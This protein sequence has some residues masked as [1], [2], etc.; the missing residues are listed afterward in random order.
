M[1]QMYIFKNTEKMWSQ[2]PAAIPA[3]H[4]GLAVF[5]PLLQHVLKPMQL[6]PLAAHSSTSSTA[7]SGDTARGDQPFFLASLMS[8]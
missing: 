8:C 5:L 6:V 2:H 1:V 7:C 4:A 3:H